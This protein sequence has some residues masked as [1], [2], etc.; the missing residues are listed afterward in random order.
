[1]LPPSQRH[2]YYQVLV[3]SPTDIGLGQTPTETSECANEQ[4]VH[5]N[6]APGTQCCCPYPL[7]LN[8]GRLPTRTSTYT[9]GVSLYPCDISSTLCLYH[10]DPI[11]GSAM[12]SVRASAFLHLFDAPN[13]RRSYRERSTLRTEVLPTRVSTVTNEDSLRPP[14]YSNTRCS[15]HHRQMSKTSTLPLRVSISADE[16]SLHLLGNTDNRCSCHQ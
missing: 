9:G 2:R 11:L 3:S 1:M 8:P 16:I 4:F 13:T 12:G 14:N 10:H 5:L 15:Y 6:G 7:I